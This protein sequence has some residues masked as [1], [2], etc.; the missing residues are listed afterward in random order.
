MGAVGR[1]STGGLAA[2]RPHRGPGR[3][4]SPRAAAL[5]DARLAGGRRAAAGGAPGRRAAARLRGRGTAAGRHWYRPDHTRSGPAG[6]ELSRAE[7]GTLWNCG[8][9]CWSWGARRLA[10]LDGG[11]ICRTERRGVEGCICRSGRRAVPVG[12]RGGLYL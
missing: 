2:C 8:I 9:F 10:Q 4:P 6:C 5:G 12:L 11:C 7:E 1:R 3:R